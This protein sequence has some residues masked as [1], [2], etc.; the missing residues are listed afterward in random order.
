MTTV[1]VVDARKSR[2][3]VR[4]VRHTVALFV[5]SLACLLLLAIVVGLPD[6]IFHIVAEEAIA[7]CWLAEDPTWL[8]QWVI[9]RGAHVVFRG[10]T[11]ITLQCVDPHVE[12]EEV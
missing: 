8:A 3:A 12:V 4:R 10:A 5:Y 1:L 2:A 6:S 11:R 7:A 9:G